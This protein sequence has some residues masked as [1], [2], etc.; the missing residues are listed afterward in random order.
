MQFT[1][2]AVLFMASVA[3]ALPAPA[4]AAVG[5]STLETRFNIISECAGSKCR[6]DGKDYD[7]YV[8]TCADGQHCGGPNV[9][10]LACNM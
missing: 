8:G 4:P 10:N 1:S 5:F 6:V 7:C 2:L 9:N 3:Y